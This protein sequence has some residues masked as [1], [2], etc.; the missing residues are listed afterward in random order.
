MG[1]RFALHKEQIKDV[2]KEY[3]IESKIK[4]PFKDKRPGDDWFSA[5]KERHNL[6]VKRPE[7]IEVTRR[8]ITSK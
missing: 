8:T 6:T 4:N 1:I 7:A 3:V 2:F 5:F